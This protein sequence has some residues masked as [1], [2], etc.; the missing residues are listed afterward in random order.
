MGFRVTPDRIYL[1]VLKAPNVSDTK[2]MRDIV[3]HQSIELARVKTAYS[4]VPLLT[5]RIVPQA[6]NPIEY[7]A[8]F[9]YEYQHHGSM[10]GNWFQVQ[11]VSLV[12]AQ[13]QP[14][15]I[16]S[17]DRFRAHH[18]MTG[19]WRVSASIAFIREDQD[20]QI[21]TQVS[22]RV[23]HDQNRDLYR[24]LVSN[25]LRSLGLRFQ[26][27]ANFEFEV[28]DNTTEI[29]ASGDLRRPRQ[30]QHQTVLVSID[31]L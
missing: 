20:R 19:I 17:L 12:T 2:A 4:F 24:E 14:K 21:Q 15:S 27:L 5:A 8:V 22:R 9:K 28:V 25:S 16:F 13:L 10:I 11:P 23:N 26:E 1:A 18:Q 7:R 3:K 6:V 30:E 31:E 29:L